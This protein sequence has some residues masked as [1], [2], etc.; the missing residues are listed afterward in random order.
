MARRGTF[1]QVVSITTSGGLTG[2]DR[3]ALDIRVEADGCG[4]VSTQAAEK[5]YRVL[6]DDP[7]IRIQTRIDIAEARPL[8][9][10]GAGGDP[11]RPQPRAPQPQRP[12][13]G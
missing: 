6:P 1:P 4:T 13:C 12:S 10:A 9:M 8:R 2:G 11:V 5:L 3:I 7:D